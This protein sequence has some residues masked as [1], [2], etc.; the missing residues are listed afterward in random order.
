MENNYLWELDP[1]FLCLYLLLPSLLLLLFVLRNKSRSKS[2]LN[3]PPSPPSFPIIGNLHQLAKDPHRSLRSLSEKYGPLML[4]NLGRVPT[5]V[6]SSPDLVGEIVNTNDVVFSGRPKTTATEIL[7]YEHKNVLF[8]PYGE[9]W[10]QA[11]KIC[12]VE[13]LSLKRVQS[14]QKVREQE[15]DALVKEI[16]KEGCVSGSRPINLSKMLIEASNHLMSRCVL[17]HSY[18]AEDGS[19]R[20]LGELSN[21]MSMQLMAFGFGDFFPCLRWIDVLRGFVGR[22]RSTFRDFDAFNDQVVREHKAA[23]KVGHD[24]SEVE[25]LVDVLLRLQQDSMLDFELTQD[26]IKAILQVN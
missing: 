23:R 19:I 7:F 5:L 13:L 12:V 17:G 24:G 6:V 4:L 14:F 25:D 8:A 22:M 16:R 15:V 2:Q 3:L 11:R 9:Y 18:K 26:H 20:R 10:R 21:D 1:L